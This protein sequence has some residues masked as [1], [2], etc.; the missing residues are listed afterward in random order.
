MQHIFHELPPSITDES[1]YVFCDIR[2]IILS[3]CLF[4]SLLTT[5]LSEIIGVLHSLHHIL[6][7]Q[8]GET[9]TNTVCVNLKLSF[10]LIKKTRSIVLIAKQEHSFE[11]TRHLRPDRFETIKMRKAG[12]KSKNVLHPSSGF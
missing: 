4:V 8:L 6:V 7:Y 1:P 12:V 10:V 5:T 11:E 2:K 3:V 9:M